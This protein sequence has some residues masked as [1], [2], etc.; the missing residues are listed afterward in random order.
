MGPS[1]RYPNTSGGPLFFVRDFL[2]DVYV[3]FICVAD[4]GDKMI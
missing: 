4:D 3:N 2:F 1:A